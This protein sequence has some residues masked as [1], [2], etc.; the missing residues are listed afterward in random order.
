MK[1][2]NIL[3]PGRRHSKHKHEEREVKRGQFWVVLVGCFREG[4]HQLE[5]A[6]FMPCSLCSVSQTC[7][8]DQHSYVRVSSAHCKGT[9]SPFTHSFSL[10]TLPPTLFISSNRHSYS[11]LTFSIPHKQPLMHLI[12]SLI[13]LSFTCGSSSS[14][15]HSLTP[16]TSS[17]HSCPTSQTSP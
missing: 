15:K 12:S 11:S 10:Q 5:N 9:Y 7:H 2:L 13:S 14:C 1:K 16:F 6:C 8:L 3:K 4:S 17:C